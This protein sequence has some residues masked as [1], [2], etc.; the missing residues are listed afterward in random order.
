MSGELEFKYEVEIKKTEE[1]QLIPKEVMVVMFEKSEE[2][3]NCFEE[4]E[5]FYNRSYIAT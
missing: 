1:R 4:E 3:L 5:L 2:K